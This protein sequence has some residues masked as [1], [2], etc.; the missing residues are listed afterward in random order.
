MSIAFVIDNLRNTKLMLWEIE[1]GYNLMDMGE[2][3]DE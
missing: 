1:H 3:E 2:V